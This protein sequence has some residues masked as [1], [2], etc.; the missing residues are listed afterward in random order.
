MNVTS[1]ADWDLSTPKGYRRYLEEYKALLIAV[2]VM[3]VLI[4]VERAHSKNP[5]A[6][7][8]VSGYTASQV[9]VLS[10]EL[11]RCGWVC[12][13]LERATNPTLYVRSKR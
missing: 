10:K 6:W 12:C 2:D 13:S 4:A 11:G 9:D 5:D 1:N 8:R 3:G 7:Y